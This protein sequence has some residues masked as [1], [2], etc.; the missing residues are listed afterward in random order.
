MLFFFA[1]I[2]SRLGLIELRVGLYTLYTRHIDT[3]IITFVYTIYQS[4]TETSRKNIR[5]THESTQYIILYTYTHHLRLKCFRFHI[6]TLV[7]QY[8]AAE[9]ARAFAKRE[10]LKTIVRVA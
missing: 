8:T 2:I 5:F 1:R 4:Y 10:R 6:Y 3:H 7:L 9:R